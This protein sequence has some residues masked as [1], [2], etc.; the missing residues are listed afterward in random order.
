[1]TDDTQTVFSVSDTAKARI[2][3]ILSDEPADTK[4]RISVL[5]GGCS[6]F[7]YHFDLDADALKADDIHF[8]DEQAPVIIDETSLALVKGA[9]LDYQESLGSSAFAIVNPNATASCGCGNSFSV[10]F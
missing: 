7:Q 6:G 4:F 8:G 3:F 10:G 5:G 9:Q 1:M 2:K